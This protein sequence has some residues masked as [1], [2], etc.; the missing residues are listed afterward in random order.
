MMLYYMMHRSLKYPLQMMFRSLN[1]PNYTMVH[2]LMSL[3]LYDMMHRSLKDPLQ[4]TNDVAF[5][6]TSINDASF[7]MMLCYMMHRSLKKTL[8]LQSLKYPLQMMTCSLKHP[9]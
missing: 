9:N 7:S 3:M 4:M 1:H 6:K 2:S 8:G 5:F